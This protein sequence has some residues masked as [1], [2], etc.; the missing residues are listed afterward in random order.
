M[1]QGKLFKDLHAAIN[2]DGDTEKS[3]ATKIILYLATKNYKVWQQQNR[4]IFDQ[5]RAT[6]SLVELFKD[7]HAA[8][9]TVPINEV[10]ENILR[11]LRMSF[12][13]LETTGLKGVSDIIGFNLKT[14]KWIA[15]E[16]K[17]NKDTVSPEQ[18]TFINLINTSGGIAFEA[19]TFDQFQKSFEEKIK[20]V[21]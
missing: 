14:G 5:N 9:E 16:I 8:N 4:G 2:E 3:L 10:E 7:L 12:N 19:K 17:I 21:K 15:I 13:K 1:T 11:A 6:R 20:E 18:T